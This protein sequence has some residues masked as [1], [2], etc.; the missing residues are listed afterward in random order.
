LLLTNLGQ[1]VSAEMIAEW[2]YWRW[3]IE[4]YFKLCKSAGQHLEEWQ[5]E[6]APAI[7]KRLLIAAMACIVVWQIQRDDSSAE[8]ELRQLLL[9][10]SGRQVRRGQATAP[11][12]L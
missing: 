4:S 12:L 10:L 11:A 6:T 9:R 1:E 5:Q 3:I 7:A 2:Y 8:A